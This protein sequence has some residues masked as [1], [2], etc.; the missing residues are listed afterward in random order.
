MAVQCN[1]N[2]MMDKSNNLKF[3][4]TC[5][6]Y[7]KELLLEGLLVSSADAEESV[8]KALFDH[9]SETY[10]IY[11]EG[12]RRKSIHRAAKSKM[13]GTKLMS[14]VLS[15][16]KEVKSTRIKHLESGR[17]KK[18]R[19]GSKFIIDKDKTIPFDK[20]EHLELSKSV[21]NMM[22]DMEEENTKLD[23]M[24]EDVIEKICSYLSN[25]D[26]ARLEQTCKQINTEIDRIWKKKATMILK[27][28][29]YGFL[30]NVFKCVLEDPEEHSEKYC[31]KWVIR[32]V[33]VT[34][35]IL[36]QFQG[37]NIFYGH[38]LQSNGEE[39]DECYGI[40]E[41]FQSLSE[42]ECRVGKGDTIVLQGRTFAI[43]DE[44]FSYFEPTISVSLSLNFPT[45]Y[46]AW[47]SEYA[48]TKAEL[49]FI[50]RDVV[51]ETM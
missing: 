21:L 3:N 20:E 37:E 13:L 30:E 40:P 9:S 32:L 31:S 14:P 27:G 4:L 15:T 6:S 22:E 35:E 33:Q 18:M 23:T 25:E 2:N 50:A 41:Y 34:N 1:K 5:K 7:L 45:L 39:Y 19:G 46:K 11:G 48:L 51:S 16:K 29:P 26:I 8:G 38:P 36:E 49:F 12:Y 44:E 24:G 43:K 17:S 10:K 47:L 42:E 28:S